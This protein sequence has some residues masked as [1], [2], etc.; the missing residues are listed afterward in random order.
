MVHSVLSIMTILARTADDEDILR[1]S[2][3]ENIIALLQEKFKSSA[4]APQNFTD[5]NECVN[6]FVIE[7]TRVQVYLIILPQ[8]LTLLTLMT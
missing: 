3:P 6:V 8:R 4:R 1:L 5:G 7:P 2:K